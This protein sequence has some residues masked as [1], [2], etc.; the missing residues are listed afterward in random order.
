MAPDA[1][2]RRDYPRTIDQRVPRFLQ[3]VDEQCQRS[4]EDGRHIAVRDAVSQQVLGFTQLLVRL[5]GDGELHLAALGRKWPDLGDLFAR[6]L[7]G[8]RGVDPTGTEH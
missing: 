8:L 5:G 4:L 7:H 6:L 1:G 3:F 2:A